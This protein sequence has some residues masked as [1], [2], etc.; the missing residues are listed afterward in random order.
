M[1]RVQQWAAGIARGERTL[2]VLAEGERL[3]GPGTVAYEHLRR[4][5]LAA[6]EPVAIVSFLLWLVGADMDAIAARMR[7]SRRAA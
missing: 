4:F 6:E 1:M 5:Y 2:H 7:A 3:A